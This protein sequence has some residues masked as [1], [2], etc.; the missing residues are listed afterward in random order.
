[1]NVTKISLK[2]KNKN[3]LSIEE[4]IIEREKMFYCNYK[5]VF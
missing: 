1:M 4:N 5:K 3:L 2:R